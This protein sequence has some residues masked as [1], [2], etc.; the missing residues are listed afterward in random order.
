MVWDRGY[1]DDVVNIHFVLS[2]P[3]VGWEGVAYVAAVLKQS[4][5]ASSPEL[6][7][8]KVSSIGNAW[9]YSLL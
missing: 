2:V 4:S 1:F 6:G 5:M 7:A 8:A 3:P 9:R